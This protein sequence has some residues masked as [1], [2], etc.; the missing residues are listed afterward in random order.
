MSSTIMSASAGADIHM[1]ATPLPVPPHGPGVV[2]DGS[3]TVMT[4][5]LPQSRLGDTIIEAVGPP[6]KIVKGQMNVIVG[7]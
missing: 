2:I 5:F 4:T 1:C 6:N 7:G 3:T